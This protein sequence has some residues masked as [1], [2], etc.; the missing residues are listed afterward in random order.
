MRNTPKK[1]DIWISSFS[2]V[3]DPETIIKTREFD[4]LSVLKFPAY[5]K[6]E[7]VSKYIFLYHY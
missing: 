5:F 2:R 6:N 1:H 7:I 4:E 3:T